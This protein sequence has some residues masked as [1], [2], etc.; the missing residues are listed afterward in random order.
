[1]YKE[2][3]EYELSGDDPEMP[4]HGILPGGNQQK[5][6]MKKSVAKKYE[7]KKQGEIVNAR[8]RTSHKVLVKG[9]VKVGSEGGPVQNFHR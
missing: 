2:T 1:M 8:M 9:V 3:T 4:L 6:S 7:G 5:K